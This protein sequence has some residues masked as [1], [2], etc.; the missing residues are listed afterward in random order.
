MATKQL[1]SHVSDIVFPVQGVSCQ[2]NGVKESLRVRVKGRVVPP[3]RHVIDA[4]A[5]NQK[6]ET[7]PIDPVKQYQYRRPNKQTIYGLRT[8][9]NSIVVSASYHLDQHQHSIPFTLISTIRRT[10][11]Q[12]KQS[13][14][15]ITTIDTILCS[16]APLSSSH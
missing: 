7:S 16:C 4:C 3:M 1:L 14:S 2:R 5:A 11:S 9:S 12:L 15:S 13:T 8:P 6:L 10:P